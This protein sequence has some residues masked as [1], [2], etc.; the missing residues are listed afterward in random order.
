[1]VILCSTV[2][3]LSGCEACDD[4][5]IHVQH[6]EKNIGKKNFSDRHRHL[7]YLV[8]EHRKICLSR[9]CYWQRAEKWKKELNLSSRYLVFVSTHGIVT[10]L[11]MRSSFAAAGVAFCCFLTPAHE[12]IAA[13]QKYFEF[14]SAFNYMKMMMTTIIAYIWLWWKNERKMVCLRKWIA[15]NNAWKN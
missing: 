3:A 15:I 1:M 8:N 9:C 10:E 13:R 5:I 7:N 2:F 12:T 14:S 11:P 6:C 4:V